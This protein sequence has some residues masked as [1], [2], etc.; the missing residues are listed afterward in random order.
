MV[1]PP[2]SPSLCSWPLALVN[3]SSFLCG[4]NSLAFVAPTRADICWWP[5][6]LPDPAYA[7][8]WL[9]GLPGADWLT[10]SM[11]SGVGEPSL[12]RHSGVIRPDMLMWLGEAGA[13][14]ELRPN[15]ARK[16]GTPRCLRR[17]KACS[18]SFD[19]DWGSMRQKLPLPGSSWLRGTCTTVKRLQERRKE[20]FRLIGP[21]FWLLTKTSSTNYKIQAVLPIV[22]EEISIAPIFVRH[23]QNLGTFSCVS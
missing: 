11:C 9:P 6:M 16:H 23:C 10:S 14:L 12:D 22:G 17:R 19:S 1:T 4:S 8:V 13:L 7:T 15:G 5:I 20:Q 18:I 3:C 2:P 21:P